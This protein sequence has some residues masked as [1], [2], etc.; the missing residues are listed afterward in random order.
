MKISAHVQ[1]DTKTVQLS[2]SAKVGGL[3]LYIEHSTK[4][5]T[6]AKIQDKQVAK[7]WSNGYV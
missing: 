5:E 6:V 7:L 4:S 1:H 2:R 3:N